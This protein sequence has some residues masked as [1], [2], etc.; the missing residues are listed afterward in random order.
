M[1]E[2]ADEKTLL[3]VRRVV[4]TYTRDAVEDLENLIYL[5]KVEDQSALPAEQSDKRGDLIE[6]GDAVE[7]GV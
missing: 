1:L 6:D 4:M 7:N 2:E 5:G 3:Q